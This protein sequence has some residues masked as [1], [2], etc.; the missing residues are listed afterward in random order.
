MCILI[1]ICYQIYVSPSVCLLDYKR[2]IALKLGGILVLHLKLFEISRKKEGL[3]LERFN[4]S[5]IAFFPEFPEKRVLKE[6]SHGCALSF[7]Y[8]LSY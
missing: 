3:F 1:S 5:W 7:W 8:S 4:T 6:S 2:L